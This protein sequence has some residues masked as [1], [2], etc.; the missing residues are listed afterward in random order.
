VYYLPFKLSRQSALGYMPTRMGRSVT[1]D[2]NGDPMTLEDAVSSAREIVDQLRARWK[3]IGMP[4]EGP[5][6]G[7]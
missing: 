1:E 4:I 3:Q 6:T 2:D 7:R 5:C